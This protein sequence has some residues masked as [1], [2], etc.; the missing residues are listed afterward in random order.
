M[1]KTR[2]E[3]PFTNCS[4][5]YKTAEKVMKTSKVF[6]QVGDKKNSTYLV[7]VKIEMLT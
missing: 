5:K 3:Y 2:K 4:M 6:I 1:H 7:S